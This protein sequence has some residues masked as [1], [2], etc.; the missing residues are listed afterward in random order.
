MITPHGKRR[1]LGQFDTLPWL[2]ESMP[3]I[4]CLNNADAGERGIKDGDMVRV[5]ND[6]GVLLLPVKV[7][8]R[9]MPGVVLIESGAW[10]NPDKDGV[11]RGGNTNVLI[12][13][14]PS[15]GG[16]FSYNNCLVEVQKDA[17]N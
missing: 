9:I 17:K 15:A 4:V 3:Q 13:D 8:Q 6:R 2:R 7:T 5:Y 10:Y 12:S 1:A 11:D 16:H 14:E